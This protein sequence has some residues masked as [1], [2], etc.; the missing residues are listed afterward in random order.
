MESSF[1]FVITWAI[2]VLPTVL[3]SCQKERKKNQVKK[4]PQQNRNRW[5]IWSPR[6]LTFLLLLHQ[7]VRRKQDMKVNYLWARELSA[8]KNKA[9]CWRRSLINLLRVECTHG[10]IYRWWQ[11]YGLWHRRRI[12]HMSLLS[13]SFLRRVNDPVRKM[14]DQ[15]S[16]HATQDSNKH[17]WMWECLC[18]QHYKH[19][20]SWKRNTQKNSRSI[21]NTRKGSHHE[22]GVRHIWKVDYW[23]MK[24]DLN[25]DD[26]AWQQFS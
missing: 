24:W 9:T 1:V 19:P 8:S 4:E 10:Q 22:T 5:W 16:K 2:S 18:L 7:K 3:K 21:Q 12:M 6:L 20:F 13:R 14:L 23:T 25:W 11:W 15:S 17:S 26:S